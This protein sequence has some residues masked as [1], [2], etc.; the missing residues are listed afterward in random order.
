MKTYSSMNEMWT[1][2]CRTLREFGES[3][4]SRAGDSIEVVGWSGRLV[5]TDNNL[6]T[7]RVRRL[8][9]AYACAELLWYLSGERTVERM[10]AYAPQYKRFANPQ[11]EDGIAFG[12][13]GHRWHNNPGFKEARD[14]VEHLKGYDLSSQLDAAV[15]LLE[16]KPETRQAVVT[17]WDSGDLC[18]AIIGRV[19]DLPCTLSMQFIRRGK[20]LHCSVCMRS[21]DVWLG[22][23]YDVFCFTSIQRIVARRLGLRAGV[24]MH[25][26]GSLHAYVR[27]FDK[28]FDLNAACTTYDV[29]YGHGYSEDD[30]TQRASRQWDVDEAL[31]IEREVRTGAGA[32]GVNFAPG[33]LLG[34]AAIVCAAG[35]AKRRQNLPVVLNSG[36][37]VALRKAWELKYPD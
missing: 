15:A 24:Y 12:A 5:C 3:H 27:D 10:C 1:D 36:V 33:G 11:S 17:M 30:F 2:T 8:D 14:V 18:E 19:N 32:R 6:L 29:A 13:Y 31:A 26:V 21:N 34:D 7:S 16:A 25:N 22:M 28:G 20:R 9:P 35:L 4:A 37:S 23:P